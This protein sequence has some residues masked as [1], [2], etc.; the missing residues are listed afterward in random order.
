VQGVWFRA[1]TRNEALLLGIDGHALNLND[2]SVEVL[3]A[4]APDALGQLA[5]WLEHGPPQARVESV[6]RSVVEVEVAPGFRVG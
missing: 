4:G 2:G 1:S 3:A 6:E 5:N